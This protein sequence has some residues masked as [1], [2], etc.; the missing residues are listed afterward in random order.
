MPPAAVAECA[1]VDGFTEATSCDHELG[2]TLGSRFSLSFGL[3]PPA[4]RFP[5]QRFS[6]SSAP[7][8][9]RAR[10]AR[11]ELRGSSL[12]SSAVEAPGF[13]RRGSLE[14]RKPT[15]GHGAQ[16]QTRCKRKGHH[17]PVQD[18]ATLRPAGRNPLVHGV[19]G[20]R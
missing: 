4:R 16:L 13:R 6:S 18:V 12:R 20:T 7:A 9:L 19:P 15:C 2:V 8:G 14:R 10:S 17:R 3:G 5:L 11:A 1:F